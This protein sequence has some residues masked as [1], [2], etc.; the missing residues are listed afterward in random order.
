MTV[1]LF[2]VLL[3][4]WATIAIAVTSAQTISELDEIRGRLNALGETQKTIVEFLYAEEPFVKGNEACPGDSY[5]IDIEG[6]CALAAGYFS[7]LDENVDKLQNKRMSNPWKFEHEFFDESNNYFGHEF[8]CFVHIPADSRSN[9]PLIEYTVC[10]LDGCKKCQNSAT[11]LSYQD[12]TRIN[13]GPLKALCLCTPEYTGKY[14]EVKAPLVADTLADG[15]GG[16]SHRTKRDDNLA[17]LEKSVP[18]IPGEDYPI[19]AE[20]PET[21]FACDGRV[22]GV[23]YADP[24]A[25]CQV[26]RICTADGQGGLAKY[27]FLCP[28]GTIFNQNYFI[29]DWWFNF[30]CTEAEGLYSLNDDYSN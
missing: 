10:K 27:S 23:Y 28:N 12:G 5:P 29:C 4:L 24:E 22:D 8:G 16:H 13:P 30:D 11:C 19:Y 26:F 3:G 18:G 15:F 9:S 17:M 25:D 2:W 1:K 20:V 6:D 14:C 21:S 7:N